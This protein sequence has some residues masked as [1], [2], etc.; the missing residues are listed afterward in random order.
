MTH[1]LPRV[2]VEK[3]AVTSFAFAL[4]L[5]ILEKTAWAICAIRRFFRRYAIVYFAEGA[6]GTLPSARYIGETPNRTVLAQ[7]LAP[8]ALVFTYVAQLAVDRATAFCTGAHC[9][10]YTGG[11]VGGVGV[12][13]SVAFHALRHAVRA[14]VFP[15]VAFVALGGRG[16]GGS[17]KQARG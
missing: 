5:V 6:H 9:T 1:R 17:S 4:T 7:G 10:G 2:R 13:P 15:R 16:S 3:A 8:G 12:A 14:G 11:G